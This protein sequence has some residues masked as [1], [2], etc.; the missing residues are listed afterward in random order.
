MKRK[1][2]L[3]ITTVSLFSSDRTTMNRRRMNTYRAYSCTPKIIKDSLNK[4]NLSRDGHLLHKT[5][6]EQD[7]KLLLQPHRTSSG[8]FIYKRYKSYDKKDSFLRD[9]YCDHYGRLCQYCEVLNTSCFYDLEIPLNPE[10]FKT[11]KQFFLKQQK[12]TEENLYNWFSFWLHQLK[13]RWNMM[14]R[15]NRLVFFDYDKFFQMNNHNFFYYLFQFTTSCQVL[16]KDPPNK[17]P[18]PVDMNGGVV[19]KPNKNIKTKLN[20]VA[21]ITG[22]AMIRFTYQLYKGGGRVADVK[23]SNGKSVIRYTNDITDQSIFV[24]MRQRM[25][26]EENKRWKRVFQYTI[27]EIKNEVRFRPGMCGM[28]ECLASFRECLKYYN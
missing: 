26:R 18:L 12:W 20:H 8:L 21:I 5:Y 2:R 7:D 1:Q 10:D 27:D 25:L 23:T 24:L 17:Q 11:W 14:V 13:N 9:C 15:S 6:D 19:R 4:K 16:M 22:D 28:E 3:K